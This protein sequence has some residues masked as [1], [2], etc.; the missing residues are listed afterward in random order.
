MRELKNVNH[1]S[2]LVARIY[3]LLLSIPT[4]A[5]VFPFLFVPLESV[6]IAKHDWKRGIG[7]ELLFAFCLVDIFICVIG[8][9]LN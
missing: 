8:H 9:H 4:L 7:I 3:T 6:I 5:T 2:V 1:D